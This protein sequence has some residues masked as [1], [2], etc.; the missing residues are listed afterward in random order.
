MFFLVCSGCGRHSGVAIDPV[1]GKLYFS[2][3]E[4]KKIEVVRMDGSGR[5]TITNCTAKPL[6]LTLD[7]KER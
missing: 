2:N 7:L 6:R 4:G 5:T 3:L 1:E